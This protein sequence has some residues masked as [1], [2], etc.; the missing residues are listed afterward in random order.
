MI[1]SPTKVGRYKGD[2][3]RKDV[4]ASPE[5]CSILHWTSIDVVVDRASRALSFSAPSYFWLAVYACIHVCTRVLVRTQV[6]RRLMLRGNL[7]TIEGH[8][9]IPSLKRTCSARDGDVHICEL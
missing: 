3:M 8:R 5:M 2:E 7:I 4:S 9:I 6:S 1:L